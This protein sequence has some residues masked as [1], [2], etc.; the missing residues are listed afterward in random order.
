MVA[1]APAPVGELE[2][3]RLEVLKQLEAATKDGNEEGIEKLRE[4]LVRMNRDGAVLRDQYY[5]A[6][7]DHRRK[8]TKAQSLDRAQQERLMMEETRRAVKELHEEVQQLRREGLVEA[9]SG[10]VEILKPEVMIAASDF[11]LPQPKRQD[12]WRAEGPELRPPI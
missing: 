1:E 7:E 6:Q 12:T 8:F 11:R 10:Y 2:A 5:S 3:R 4:E 9:R